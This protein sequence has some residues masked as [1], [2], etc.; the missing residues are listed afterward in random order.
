MPYCFVKGGIESYD[1]YV[2]SLSKDEARAIISEFKTSQ[3]EVDD[4]QCNKA[5]IKLPGAAEPVP[6]K[7]VRSVKVIESA[8]FVINVLERKFGYRVVS[9]VGDDPIVWTMHR[10]RESEAIYIPPIIDYTRE[11]K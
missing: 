8:N 2:S 1:C 3:R 5:T 7:L 4:K 9:A 11:D 6:F 10:W